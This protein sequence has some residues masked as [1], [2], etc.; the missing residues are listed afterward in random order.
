[1]IEEGTDVGF[2]PSHGHASKQE[3]THVHTHAYM[4]N[5]EIPF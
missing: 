3:G 4:H 2:E 1:M 5:Q